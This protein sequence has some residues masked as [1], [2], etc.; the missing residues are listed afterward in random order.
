MSKQY[1]TA[2]LAAF[3]LVV[4]PVSLAC[5]SGQEEAA[6][7]IAVVPASGML[8]LDLGVDVSQTTADET[9]R[10]QYLVA[11]ATAVQEV[12]DRGGRLRLSVFF[13][14]GLQP[15]TLIDADVP[16]PEELGGVARAQQLVPLREAATD[17]LAEALG[18]VPRRSRIAQALTGLGGS[19]T[20]V[21]GS[22]A[23][24]IAAV[25]GDGYTLVLRLSDGID[26]RWTGDLDLPAEVL[27]D[28]VAPVLP[29]AGGGVTVALV[30]IGA[31][32]D[33]LS[34]GTTQRIIRAWR[35]ACRRT[36]AR[37]CV[38]PDPDLGRLFG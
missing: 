12:I 16:T 10:R 18:L 23:G 26:Q 9:L 5:G 2:C 8:G 29:P 13:S 6:D 11:G 37:C 36:G 15:V 21:A 31:T 28:R 4:C 3:A 25:G 7:G 38:S 22:L 14:R 35:S 27:A 32:A 1:L 17:A 20:D 33:G 24:G 19:G 34:T 30:G